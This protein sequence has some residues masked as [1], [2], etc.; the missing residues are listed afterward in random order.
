MHLQGD[1]FHSTIHI[2]IFR[3]Q[4]TLL[5]PIL[6]IIIM[7]LFYLY[8]SQYMYVVVIH[9]HWAQPSAFRLPAL[10]RTR[11]AV[12]ATRRTRQ[13]QLILQRF[14]SAATWLLLFVEL[15]VSPLSLPLHPTPLHILRRDL[16]NSLFSSCQITLRPFTSR[17]HELA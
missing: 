14:S 1:C 8:P 2:T 3:V 4:S 15:L 16:L 7:N 9:K 12:S 13:R 10:P 17:K 5:F 6:P 11:Q